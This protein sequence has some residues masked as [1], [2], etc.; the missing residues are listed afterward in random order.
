[1]NKRVTRKQIEEARNYLYNTNK[2]SGM[3]IYDPELAEIIKEHTPVDI[4]G[5]NY[6]IEPAR[7][8]SCDGCAFQDTWRCP[9]RAINYCT[10]NGGNILIK[11]EP[12][13]K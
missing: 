11:A 7:G 8:G 6:Y 10:S 13:K 4:L 9:Q 2:Q 1:M 5:T 12:N 3:I